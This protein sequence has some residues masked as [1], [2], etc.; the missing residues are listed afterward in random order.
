MYFDIDT[1]HSV[2]CLV[3]SAGQLHIV[4]SIN[5]TSHLKPLSHWD[6]TTGD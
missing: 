1:A 3:K 5:Y 6:A 2:I 4:L